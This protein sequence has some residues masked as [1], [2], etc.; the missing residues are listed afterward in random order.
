[1][2]KIKLLYD[3]DVKELEINNIWDSHGNYIPWENENGKTKEIFTN[4]H[5]KL[6]EVERTI[7]GVKLAFR[8][9]FIDDKEYSGSIYSC[10]GDIKKITCTACI[11]TG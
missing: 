3:A 11:G 7:Y 9:L 8:R 4:K 2:E 1:M 5:I 10:K 6:E